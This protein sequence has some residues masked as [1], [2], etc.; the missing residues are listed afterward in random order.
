M[1][2]IQDLSDLI[3]EELDASRHY[4]DE[5]LKWYATCPELSETFY[6]LSQD[7]FHHQQLLHDEVVSLIREYNSY[8]GAPP[9]EMLAVYN[10]I[11]D[12]EIEKAKEI[13][14]LQDLYKSKI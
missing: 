10:Y 8:H 3:K 6:H 5:A 9:K 2:I 12:I 14:I 11:H 1:K 7:E 13:L 4:I